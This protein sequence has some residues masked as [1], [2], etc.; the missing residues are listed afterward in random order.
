MLSKPLS[1]PSGP[2]P[3]AARVKP[4]H[5]VAGETD[6]ERDK[7]RPA[8]RL[9][10]ERSHRPLLIGRL[11]AAA[12]RK[13]EGKDAD[14][15]VDEAARDEPGAREPLERPAVDEF[16]GG[17]VGV[18]VGVGVVTD[19]VDSFCLAL[20][21]AKPLG[22]ALERIGVSLGEALGLLAGLP[23]LL[24][25][26]EA[27]V[28]FDDG[29]EARIDM[30]GSGKTRNRRFVSRTDRYSVG[31]SSSTREQSVCEHSQRKR[32]GTSASSTEELAT[33]AS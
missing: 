11:A 20:V 23:V 18:A 28:L 16:A 25:N 8:E 26:P 10:G 12:D 13:L 1:D 21:C 17:V 5:R 32:S 22:W 29:L 31:V 15:P 4:P 6:R 14:D 24:D 2:R 19:I 7:H 9:L 3:S 30:G 27:L 33:V